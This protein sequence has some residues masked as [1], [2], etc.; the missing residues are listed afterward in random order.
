M[1]LSVHSGLFRRVIIAKLVGNPLFEEICD[2]EKSFFT[3]YIELSKEKGYEHYKNI[4][5]VFEKVYDRL[6]TIT[7][8][9]RE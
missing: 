5:I 4:P 1:A 9:A 2:K 3:D 6:T 7:Q 8:I